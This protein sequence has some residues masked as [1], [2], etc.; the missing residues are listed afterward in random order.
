MAVI[1]GFAEQQHQN[2]FEDYEIYIF[3]ER[4]TPYVKGDVR[5]TIV[6][7]DG[8]NTATLP[9]SRYIQTSKAEVY[10]ERYQAVTPSAYIKVR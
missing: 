8:F 5:I 3:G 10:S 6:D 2:F 9:L 1:V 7:R 4:V